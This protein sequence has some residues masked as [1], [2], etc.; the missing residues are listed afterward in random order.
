MDA[1]ESQRCRDCRVGFCLKPLKIE[2]LFNRI[3]PEGAI[4][5]FV[6]KL[7]EELAQVDMDER[8]EEFA[9]A[10]VGKSFP[11]ALTDLVGR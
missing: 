7:P 3:N 5:L 4:P 9:D 1:G 8:L 10:S 2:R 11:G 6:N